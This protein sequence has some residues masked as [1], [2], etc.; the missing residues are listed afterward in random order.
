M[1]KLKNVQ[2]EI[3]TKTTGIYYNGRGDT[4]EEALQ[5]LEARLSLGLRAAQ[6]EIDQGSRRLESIREALAEISESDEPPVEEPQET[7]ES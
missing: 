3:K 1:K 2:W 5:D 4:P 7:P 6:E